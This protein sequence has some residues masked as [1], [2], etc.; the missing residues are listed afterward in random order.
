MKLYEIL[1]SRVADDIVHLGSLYEPDQPG[2]NGSAED[3]VYSQRG[4]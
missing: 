4:C 3:G 1:E 2:A